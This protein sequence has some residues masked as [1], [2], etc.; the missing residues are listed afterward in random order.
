MCA[1]VC[2]LPWTYRLNTAAAFT[3]TF[4]LF[5][6]IDQATTQ[7]NTPKAL[8]HLDPDGERGK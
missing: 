3:Q 4:I 7:Y 5:L 8:F 6:S 2:V 1:G